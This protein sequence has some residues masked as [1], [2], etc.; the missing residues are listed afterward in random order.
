MDSSHN[1]SLSHSLYLTHSL[2]LILS[3]SW[4]TN[5]SICLTEYQLSCSLNC[6]HHLLISLFPPTQQRSYSL[7][8]PHILPFTITVCP[9]P[10]S[11]PLPFSHPNT[12][13]LSL[14]NTLTKNLLLPHLLEVRF[15][16]LG[17]GAG[18]L[19]DLCMPFASCTLKSCWLKSCTLKSFWPRLCWD[20][21]CWLR[22]CWLRSCTLRSC[23]EARFWSLKSCWMP[24]SILNNNKSRL[25]NYK[26]WE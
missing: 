19:Y 21:S 3:L 23:F 1:Y 4:F 15:I 14:S 26:W 6:K 13:N 8:Y 17:A 18:C 7:P 5:H 24:I 9:I 25:V 10:T 20:K 11:C 16:F 22:S 12:Y 2:P